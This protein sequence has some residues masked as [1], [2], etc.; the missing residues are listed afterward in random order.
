MSPLLEYPLTGKAGANE[1]D[2]TTTPGAFRGTNGS[3]PVPSSGESGANPSLAGIRL[4]AS[5]S[6][7]FPRVCGA[8]R[9]AQSTETRRTRQHRAYGR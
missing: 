3:N 4:P 5:R 2:T 9:A 1:T 8:E 7:G 6:G